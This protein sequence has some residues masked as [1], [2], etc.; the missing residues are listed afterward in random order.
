MSPVWLLSLFGVCLVA[1]GLVLVALLVLG[2]DGHADGDASGHDVVHSHDGADAWHALGWLR[3]PRAVAAGCAGF[4]SGG[5]AVWSTIA[6]G[7][8]FAPRA[9]ASLTGACVLALTFAAFSRRLYRSLGRFD[10]DRTL[11]PYHAVGLEGTVI[12]GGG[13]PPDDTPG[14][15][16]VT[17]AGQTMELRAQSDDASPLRVGVA[18][19]VL[20]V[21]H[22]D[23]V[24]VTVLPA[25]TGSSASA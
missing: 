4:G 1:G 12:V 13:T 9:A 21:V 11:T 16:S 18:V 25:V 7:L 10:E 14:R 15:V 19:R 24:S 2:H 5:L 3:S 6:H 23:L 8:S 22:E 17:V 20:D